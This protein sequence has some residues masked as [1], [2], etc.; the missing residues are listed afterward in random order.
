MGL[1]RPPPHFVY[2]G[3]PHAAIID[4]AQNKGW[5][6]THHSELETEPNYFIALVV[7][8]SLVQAPASDQKDP[9]VDEITRLR[10]RYPL[11]LIV[12]TNKQQP[13]PGVDFDLDILDEG[14][15]LRQTL[16]HAE[17]YWRNATKV[18]DLAQDLG[19]RRQRMH[20]L[21]QI[22][23][24]LTAQMTQHE[25]LQTILSEARRISHC[26]GGSLFLV[27]PNQSE[28]DS[29]VFKLAQNDVVN[30][31]FVETHLPLSSH[32]IAGYVAST[33]NELNIKD[34]YNLP[35]D[36]PYAFNRSF[37]DS[38]GY[39][40]RSILAIPMRDHRERVV[41]VLQF[42]NRVDNTRN[43]VVDFD[44]EI[45]EMLRA[46][47]SQAA[48]SIQKN[49]LIEDINS[50]FESFVQA[51]VKT[52]EQRDPSTS[53]HSFRVAQT[54]VS[55]LKALPESGVSEFKNLVLSQEH[56]REVRY[57]A[58][59]HDFGKVGVPEAILVKANKLSD[60]RLDILR[61][62][63]ELQKER[64]RRQAVEQEL[65]LLHHASMDQE[66]ARRRVHRKLEKQISILDQYFE[67]VEKANNPNVL[68]AGDFDH[69]A[70]IRDYAFREL[71][72]TIAGVIDDADLLA[73]SVRRGSLTPEE[74]RSIQS[75]VVFT[76]EFLQTLP[77][78]DEL[79]NVPEIAGAHHER[80]DGSGYPFGL[81][82]EQIPLASR[83][84]AVCDVY[85][86]L[87]AMDRPY[88][89]AMSAD[90]AFAILQ[91]EARRGL[92]DNSMVEIFIA[93]GSFDLAKAI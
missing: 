21:S 33:G 80:M 15:A 79:A 84:M 67:W 34:V 38:N 55:L 51:S 20:Q 74:R 59:L 54:T 86:A 27:E 66:V 40:T 9:G 5:Q 4:H 16:Q 88:K 71:D 89:K 25:L 60:D 64:L 8:E 39:R 75:H 92:L 81:V 12:G 68:A 7:V 44:S 24:A 36:V 53:G 50:L 43:E 11:S 46:I 78:P 57:A 76:K 31:P 32:S 49:A 10:R 41:G 56:I 63:F 90:T 47:A 26:E 52:I 6:L 28:G 29:L 1:P 93:S 61:Y 14:E 83:V 62:R 69:L 3:A 35:D 85:D 70:E 82:G 23:L 2:L 73:L 48:V 77:W 17:R 42:I 22:S 30:F 58:L 72:G 45:T 37:D 65:E 13:I 18:N 87:T 19:L 91:D